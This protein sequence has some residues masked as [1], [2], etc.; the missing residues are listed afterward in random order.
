M[1]AVSLSSLTAYLPAG[2]MRG[3]SSREVLEAVRSAALVV[4]G[5]PPPANDGP[6]LEHD[7]L[8]GERD[9]AGGEH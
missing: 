3:R 4:L 8:R 5:A 7:A 9:S 1:I 2:S 6:R